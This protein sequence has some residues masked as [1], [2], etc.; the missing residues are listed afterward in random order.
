MQYYVDRCDPFRGETYRHGKEFGQK[1]IDDCR[2]A[3]GRPPLYKDGTVMLLDLTL[4]LTHTY[5]H[6]YFPYGTAH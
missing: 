6:S 2:E 3:L 4:A 5:P 1:L